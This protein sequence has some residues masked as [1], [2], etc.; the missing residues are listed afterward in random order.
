MTRFREGE[1]GWAVD[2]KAMFSRIRL[3]PKD[4]RYHRFL[5][6]KAD[7]TIRMYQMTSHLWGSLHAFSRNPDDLERGRGF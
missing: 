6:L 3:R 4:R 5:W 7:R 1:V 2:T